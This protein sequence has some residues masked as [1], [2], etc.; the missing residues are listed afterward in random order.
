LD[1]SGAIFCRPRKPAARQ[2]IDHRHNERAVGEVPQALLRAHALA[3]EVRS[4][5]APTRGVPLRLRAVG[6][7]V[8]ALLGLLLARALASSYLR[9]VSARSSSE[10]PCQ[11]TSIFWGSIRPQIPYAP[12]TTTLPDRSTSSRRMYQARFFGP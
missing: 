9:F 7:Q 1:P 2:V 11:S 4:F 3:L 6:G 10:K 8:R 5:T 12:T